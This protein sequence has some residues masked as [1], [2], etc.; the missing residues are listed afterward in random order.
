MS[1]GF[2]WECLLVLSAGLPLTL[3]LALGSVLLGLPMALVL[4]VGTQ[5][6]SAWLRNGAQAYGV[7]WRGTPLLVQVFLVYYGLGQFRSPLETLGLW[8]AFR[9]PVFCVLLALTLNTAAY[10]AEVVRGGLLAV[11]AAQ[12]EAARAFGMSRALAA[13]RVIAPLALRSALPAYGNELV[14]MVKATALASTV[15]VMEITGLA[16]RLIAETYRSL[17]V[18]IAAA[19]LYLAIAA[20]LGALLR[21]AE[22]WLAPE[23]RARRRWH[24][25]PAAAHGAQAR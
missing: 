12:L 16:H 24:T 10:G 14:L 17:E 4:G 11:P 5:A 2:I 9:E 19:L 22:W 21:R 1:G 25:A 8:P 20:G 23:R 3:G 15:T 7:V 18:F 13:R 6:R